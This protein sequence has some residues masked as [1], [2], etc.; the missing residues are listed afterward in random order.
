MHV[1]YYTRG[2]PQFH[3]TVLTIGT[4]DGVHVGHKMILAQLL[5]EAHDIRGESVLITFHPHPRKVVQ[6]SSPIQLINTIEERIQLLSQSGIDHVVIVPFTEEFSMQSAEDYI[7]KFLISQFH[8]HT[9]IIGYDHRFGHERKGDYR[10][11]EAYSEKGAFKLM[12]ISEHLIDNNTVSATNIR[13][14]I[15]EGNIEKANE[16]LGYDF[17]FSGTVIHGDKLGRTLGYP[18]ANIQVPEGKIIP[19]NGVYAVTATIDEEGME[20][21][22]MMNIGTRPTLNGKDRR[23][24]VNL[25]DFDQDIYGRKITVKVF[26]FIRPDE[27][28]DGLETLTTAIG[29]DKKKVLAYFNQ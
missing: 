13:N 17:F 9:I 26:S 1:H 23:I 4:F 7:E 11:L 27:K 20:Y 2:L 21:R 3:K 19:G 16:L 15:L 8:P 24:E 5:E 25:F 6:S 10:M 18:T 14:A 22:G 12:E 28:F 29:E